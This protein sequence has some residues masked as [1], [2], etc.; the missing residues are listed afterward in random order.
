MTPEH[1]LEHLGS[2]SFENK[3]ALMLPFSLKNLKGLDAIFY[4][5][6]L[7]HLEIEIDPKLSKIEAYTQHLI[8]ELKKTSV[9]TYLCF[10]KKEQGKLAG[11]TQ[12]KYMDFYNYKLE[13]GGTWFGEKYQGT[14]FNHACKHLLLEHCF[15]SLNMRRV[16]FSIDADNTSSIKSM[17][18]IGATYDGL[19]KNN[20]IDNNGDS[21][22]D[23]YYS[24]IIEDWPKI[25]QEN[26]EEF[27]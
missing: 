9:Q 24:L 13:I 8:H 7:L 23:V 14:G 4:D 12:L 15:L 26:F 22:D 27:I 18:R 20:W 1:S 11:I 21:R 19:F 3:R 2:K 6:V 17:T 10:D 25:E 16:Q 5:E